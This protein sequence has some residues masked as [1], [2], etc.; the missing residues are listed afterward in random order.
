MT[1]GESDL[2]VALYPFQSGGVNQL[3]LQKG[4]Q[5]C[6]LRY[7]ASGEWCE[8]KMVC[9]DKDSDATKCAKVG[10]VGWVPSNYITPAT[11]LDMHAWYH[12]PVTRLTSEYLLSSGINGSFLV[13]DS[14]S[15]RGQ[16]SVS[17]RYNAS[18]YH[19]RINNDKDGL[20]YIASEH[21]FKTLP[22]LVHH[23]SYAS[24]G[25]VTILHYPVAKDTK[26]TLYSMSPDCDEWEVDRTEIHMKLRLGGG[27]YGDVYEAVWKRYN[28]V[29]A[30]KTFREDTTN[31][32]EFLKEAAVMKSI[33]HPNLVQLLGVCTREPPFYIVTE[34]M[35]Q[36]NLLEYLRRCD[37]TE[38]NHVVLLHMSVQIAKA[39]EY[40]E[41]RN[42]IHRDLA[43]RNCLI[44]VNNVVKVADFGL[45]RLMATGD[46][47]TARAGAKF[48]I[49][50]TAPESL[51]YN[52]F[53]TKSDVWSFGILLWE[54]ATYG[55][56]PYPGIDL[57]MVYEKL[58]NG[59]RMEAPKTCPDQLHSLMLQCWSWEVCD[60]PTFQ[61]IRQTLDHLFQ[62]P[63]KTVKPDVKPPSLPGKKHRLGESGQVPT[64]SNETDKTAV[65][66]KTSPELTVTPPTPRKENTNENNHWANNG[67]TLHSGSSSTFAAPAP[68]PP[69]ADVG[70]SVDSKKKKRQAPQPP[71]RISSFRSGDEEQ[72]P[73]VTVRNNLSTFTGQCS[74]SGEVFSSSTQRDDLSSETSEGSSIDHFG[75][76]MRRS[77]SLDI[78]AKLGQM[79]PGDSA[80]ELSD[81]TSGSGHNNAFVI[82][83]S[84]QEHFHGNWKEKKPSIFSKIMPRFKT[85]KN[86]SPQSSSV[87]PEDTDS[88]SSVP[89]SSSKAQDNSFFTRSGVRR[90]WRKVTSHMVPKKSSTKN[91]ESSDR[92]ATPHS[93]DS[94]HSAPPGGI[95]VFPEDPRGGAVP[96]SFTF[97]S[98]GAEEVEVKKPNKPVR[99]KERSR[100]V[101]DSHLHGD[102]LQHRKK[103]PTRLSEPPDQRYNIRRGSIDRS[104][105]SIPRHLSVGSDDQT[106]D[107]PPPTFKPPTPPRTPDA[108]SE[109]Q[110]SKRPTGHSPIML[111][112]S[113]NSSDAPQRNRMGSAR[114]AGELDDEREVFSG[115]NSVTAMAP[116]V[117][118]RLSLRK[119]ADTKSASGQEVS[120][121]EFHAAHQ[122]ALSALRLAL[123]DRSHVQPA[124]RDILRLVAYAHTYTVQIP[125]RNRF[126]FRE[127][128]ESLDR[129]ISGTWQRVHDHSTSDRPFQT[130]FALQLVTDIGSLL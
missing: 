80:D 13:R 56:S 90:S 42:Y 108:L 76:D 115:S 39:M 109:P 2:F 50:W 54:I 41:T 36:G 84:F 77:A 112:S 81:R 25:L 67:S 43:A 107:T 4:C 72:R 53:S 23:H 24:D 18:V 104:D 79:T 12:G 94:T 98:P 21:R 58:E 71:A 28:K 40:L 75:G 100:Y 113:G 121:E 7:N 78:A 85:K 35:S 48:P 8:A 45:S 26:P 93:D 19:Y 111:H 38:T 47:Y 29:V 68:A 92:C 16:L 126:Q 117:A 55:M 17:V 130:A 95:N 106:P 91:S 3:S 61:D 127:K 63:V 31:T 34:F 122:R 129:E 119:R 22:E 57:T 103:R 83:Q 82:S 30:V 44:E 110:G 11:S 15:C 5:L 86:Y 102:G 125:I 64:A 60:R 62:E 32:E 123:N 99:K 118:A 51:A 46:D 52:R 9:I 20:Y 1:V 96:Q 66:G 120:E 69:P 87:D 74:K 89:V 70:S 14:E 124:L 59:Y 33:K 97:P 101:D 10:S 88:V 65:S 73:Q 116:L 105:I 49:K 6:V 128:V 37:K 114:S 27:Q